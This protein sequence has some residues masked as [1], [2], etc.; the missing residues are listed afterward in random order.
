MSN[1]KI[2]EGLVPVKVTRSDGVQTTVYKR[3]EDNDASDKSISRNLSER[4]VLRDEDAFNPKNMSVST[5]KEAEELTSSLEEQPELFYESETQSKI[6]DAMTLLDSRYQA[7]RA[8]KEQLK[9]EVMGFFTERQIARGEMKSD[10]KGRYWIEVADEPTRFNAERAGLT[11]TEAAK[12]S[13]SRL[14]HNLIREHFP[15][16]WEKIGKCNGSAYSKVNNKSDAHGHYRSQFLERAQKARE[17]K[18]GNRP[19]QAEVISE[20]MRSVDR[21]DKAEADRDALRRATAE[22]AIPKEE[23]MNLKDLPGS[24]AQK[25]MD[26]NYGGSKFGN[27]KTGTSFTVQPNMSYDT[28]SFYESRYEHYEDTLSQRRTDYD[29][30]KLERMSK[31]RANRD[32]SQVCTMKIMAEKVKQNYPDKYEKGRTTRE[33]YINE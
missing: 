10:D 8:Y 15:E 24:A 7:E 5:V 28:G 33:M 9:Q 2:Q 27:P 4:S 31:M 32:W 26:D 6:A 12:C 18:L 25:Y 19:T 17:R 3:M 22:A 11:P 1:S 23:R 13:E 30:R 21:A 20:F 14:D 16:T 29:D